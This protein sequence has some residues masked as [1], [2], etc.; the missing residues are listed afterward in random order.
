M[1]IDSIIQMLVLFKKKYGGDRKVFV[2][3]DEEG[4]MISEVFNITMLTDD[5]EDDK[6]NKKKIVIWPNQ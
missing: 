1:D 5:N 2:S 4:N 6:A 3:L